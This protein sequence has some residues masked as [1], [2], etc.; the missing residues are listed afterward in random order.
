MNTEKN[1]IK[2]SRLRESGESLALQLKSMA[3]IL[4]ALVIMVILLSFAS[5]SFLTARNLLTVLRSVAIDAMVAFGMTF[6]IVGVGIDLS[7][8]SVIAFV[9]VICAI[10]IERLGIP[11]PLAILLSLFAGIL[12]G[13]VNGFIITK[14]KMLPFITTLG[15]SYIFRGAVNLMTDSQ[16]VMVSDENFYNIGT[17]Y[18][19]GIPVTVIYMIVVLVIL[20]IVLRKTKYGR[21]LYAV[22]GNETAA[23][24]SGINVDRTRMISYCIMGLM[25]A[26]AG[27]IQ[28]AKLFGGQPTIGQNA[29]MDAIA[30]AILGGTSFTG[31]VGT[32][33]G[34]LIG[35]MVLGIMNNGL[36]LLGIRSYWQYVARGAIIIVA[37]FFDVIRNRKKSKQ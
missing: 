22:G 26:A 29:E 30:A 28:C 18:V 36:N 21:K 24:F 15:T 25:A 9:S 20:S 8:G 23:R 35:T 14:M 5:E 13:A 34:T 32:L 6:V 17:G 7:V 10:F 37:V 4:C 31:G 11:V 16:A 27:V 19:A 33:S 3:G 12:I 1:S 2:N